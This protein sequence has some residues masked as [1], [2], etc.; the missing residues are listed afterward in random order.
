MTERKE[1]VDVMNNFIEENKFI[2]CTGGIV[3]YKCSNMNQFN[4]IFGYLEKDPLFNV[5]RIEY[6]YEDGTREKIKTK[7]LD[8][9]GYH[10][11]DY[12]ENDYIIGFEY[13]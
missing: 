12:Y 3:K 4:R 8:S 6:E 9:F 2:L 13:R 10:Y 11:D 1:F 7:L 5:F